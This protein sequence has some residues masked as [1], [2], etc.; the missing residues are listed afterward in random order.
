MWFVSA[1]VSV[2]ACCLLLVWCLIE[3]CLLIVLLARTLSMV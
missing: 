3:V 2:V 1:G